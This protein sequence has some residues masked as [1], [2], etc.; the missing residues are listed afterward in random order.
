MNKENILETES[1]PRLLAKFAIPSVIAMVVSAFYNIVDQFFIG[2][3]VGFLG[4]AATNVSFPLVTLCVS[5]SLLIGIGG[6]ANF[7]LN[8]G[9]KRE[10]EAKKYIVNSFFMIFIISLSITILVRIFLSNMLRIFGATD[11]IMDY[12]ISYTSI[13]SYGFIFLIITNAGT[14]LIRADGS[15]GYSMFA[16][17][18]GGI[19][20]L[21]LDPIFIF[22]FDMGVEGAAIATVAGQIISA[23]FVIGYCFHFK[24]VKIGLDD[25]KI[26]ISYM[27]N[28]AKLGLAPFFNQ[29][30]ILFVQIVIN[31]SYVHYGPLSPYG[32]E[33]PLA[34]VGIG[35]KLNMIFFSCAIGISQGMQPIVSYN[36]GAKEYERVKKTYL[37][38]TMVASIILFVA[39]L[40]F[41]LIPNKLLGLFGGGD[42]KYFEFGRIFFRVFL[43]MTFINGVQAISSSLFTS[44]GK[45]HKGILVSLSRQL[46]FFVPLALILPRFF[47]IYGI[48]F[49]GPIADFL[50]FIISVLLV[51]AEFKDL[52]R[53]KLKGI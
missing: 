39:F 42:E 40:M 25:F 52:N 20:N 26:A 18:I 4:N 21:I 47:G 9:M 48:I 12:A 43:M 50:A 27:G 51:R 24:T 11:E 34:V 53:R 49:T 1:I 31:N 23:L 30:A 2:N 44:I 13:T 28:I 32:A 14:A 3:S 37:I 19:I 45:P 7:N 17:V 16:S 5:V 10:R 35:M 15:P 36:Y 6:S 41:Q 29:I 8:M 33:I 38:S 22:G 46:I